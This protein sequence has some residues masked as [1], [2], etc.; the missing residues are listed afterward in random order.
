MHLLYYWQRENYRRDLDHGVGFHLNQSNPL[1]HA[2]VPGES[3]WAFTRARDGRYAFAAELVVSAKTLNAPGYR[4]GAYRVWGDLRRSRYFQVDGQPDIS[5]LIREIG[6]AARGDVLGRAF[7]G[8][9][10]VR[11]LDELQHLQLRFHAERLLPE[12]R[13]RLLP[14]ERLEALLLAGDDDAV[15]G[16]IRDEPSGLAEERR[17]YLSATAPLRDRAIVEELRAL[18][19]GECQICRWAPRHSYG[20]ELCETHHVRWLSRGGA[21][22]T[23]NVVLVCPNHHRAIHR[24]DAPFDFA[25]RGFVFGGRVEPLALLRHEIDPA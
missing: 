20:T 19:D 8:H 7:Q 13:A 5:L 9:A 10:A 21:D 3:L 12:P 1:L 2:I 11:R 14:E 22:E 17:R 25:S 24:C 4:Y 18:Y 15:A 6:I 16:L 23:R